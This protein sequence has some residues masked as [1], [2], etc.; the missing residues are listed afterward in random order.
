MVLAPLL[1]YRRRLIAVLILSP[2]GAELHHATCDGVSRIPA[3]PKQ[4][5]AIRQGTRRHEDQ[6]SFL[7]RDGKQ[8]GS[9][10]QNSNHLGESTIF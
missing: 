6:N 5:G 7:P 4:N 9:W 1:F 10:T 8:S 3:V 2:Q